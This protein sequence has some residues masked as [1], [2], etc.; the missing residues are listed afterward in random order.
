MLNGEENAMTVKDIRGYWLDSMESIAKPILTNLSNGSLKKNMPVRGKVDREAFAH[1]E[2][3]GRLLTGMATWLEAPANAPDE[4]NR[5]Q[6]FAQMARKAIENGVDP[7]SPDY[8]NF[9]EGT[10]PLVDAAFL[11]QAILRAPR[12]LWKKLDNRAKDNLINELKKTRQIRPHFNNWLL[13]SAM[14]ETLF[15]FIG[16]EYD[17]MRIDYALKQHEQWYKG[18]GIYGDGP[19]FRWDYYNSFVIQPMLVDIVNILG[20][21]YGDWQDIAPNI[22]GRGQ[23]YASVLEGLI[24]PEGTFPALGRSLTY[25]MGAFHLLSQMAYLEKLPEE[26]SAN[27]VRCALTAVIRKVMEMPGTFDENGWLNIGL[28]GHQPSLGETYICTGSLYLCSTVFLPL[29]LDDSKDFWRLPDMPWTSK[30]IWEGQD[31]PLDK[32]YP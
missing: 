2:A 12:E 13:F 20:D 17:P 11:A 23:R 4:E 28:C 21:K 8:M 31:M 7:N 26:L 1:L 27:Q 24:S 22:V 5:R 16:E 30:K 32:S 10:Q 9:D 19:S 29:G 6:H 15:F 14:V 25:R 3:L 18:D